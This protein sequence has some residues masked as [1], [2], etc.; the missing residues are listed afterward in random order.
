MGSTCWM[1]GRLVRVVDIYYDNCAPI[2]CSE[3]RSM[4]AKMGFFLLI[5]RMRLAK[6]GA[7]DSSGALELLRRLQLG[8]KP[9]ALCP[10]DA[11]GWK[12]HVARDADTIAKIEEAV[13]QALCIRIFEGYRAE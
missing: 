1:L 2:F 5:Q 8:D 3:R 13:C 7:C 9:I 4:P 12:A 10:E 6:G 11:R